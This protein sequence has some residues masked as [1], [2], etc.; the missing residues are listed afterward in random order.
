MKFFDLLLNVLLL[1]I[2]AVFAYGVLFFL[3]AFGDCVSEE[4]RQN[5]WFWYYFVFGVSCA[6]YGI[7]VGIIFQRWRASATRK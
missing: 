6:G 7:G 4:C 2:A 5:R 3:F 1:T